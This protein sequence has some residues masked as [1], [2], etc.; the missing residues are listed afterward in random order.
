M[1]RGYGW[2]IKQEDWKNMSRDISPFLL[3]QEDKNR[4]CNFFSSLLLTSLALCI[5]RQNT[6]PSKVSRGSP[7]A[8]ALPRLTSFQGWPGQGSALSDD[9]EGSL[10][11]STVRR[12][13]RRCT[14]STEA[15][16]LT[17][18]AWQRMGP[19]GNN[20]NL[21]SSWGSMQPSIYKC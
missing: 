11:N 16:L 13:W 12:F 14:A 2:M 6:S 18:L 19:R 17:V 3:L 1:R 10:W 15:D 7:P 20:C 21:Y 9:G 5:Y 4:S 8:S